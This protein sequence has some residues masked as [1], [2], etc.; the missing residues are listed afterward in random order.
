MKQKHVP[1]VP[2]DVSPRDYWNA[3]EE[4]FVAVKFLAVI[5]EVITLRP[6]VNSSYISCNPLSNSFK[7][8]KA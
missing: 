3:N 8:C 1:S 4:M 6:P 7:D 5:L 2:K